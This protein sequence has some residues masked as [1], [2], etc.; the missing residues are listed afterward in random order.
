LIW[1]PDFFQNKAVWKNYLQRFKPKMR[2]AAPGAH[3]LEI[4]YFALYTI[5]EK[6]QR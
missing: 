2:N 3:C 1:L 6:K 4:A 5:F